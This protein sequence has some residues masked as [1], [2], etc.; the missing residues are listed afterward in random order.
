[1]LI[2][3]S[4][5]LDEKIMISHKLEGGKKTSY[6]SL[7][8]GFTILVLGGSFRMLVTFLKMIYLVYN[9]PL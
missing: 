9:S 7:K 2:T 4:F 8:K 6:A 3:F 1:M 5:V